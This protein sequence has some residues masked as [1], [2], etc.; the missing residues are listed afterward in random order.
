MKNY[1]Q[2][3]DRIFAR[4]YGFLSFDKKW[5]EILLKIYVKT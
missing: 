3:R 1:D 4:G 5:V 2:S